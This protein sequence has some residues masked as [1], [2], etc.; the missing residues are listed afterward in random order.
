MTVMVMMAVVMMMMP[1]VIEPR[2]QPRPPRV[3]GSEPRQQSGAGLFGAQGWRAA[4]WAA[5]LRVASISA[6]R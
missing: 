5:R 2:G 3:A 1:M 6:Q 4:L